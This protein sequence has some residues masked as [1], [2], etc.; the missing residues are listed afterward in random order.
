[1][2]VFGTQ[3]YGK[4]DRVPGLFYVV[5]R[6][7]HLWFIPLFPV[8]SYL[9]LDLP[10]ETGKRGKGIPMSGKSVLHGWLRSRASSRWLS[11]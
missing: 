5:T 9:I 1:M 8:E 3:F 4:V 2:L 10:G 6:F 11:A 7:G